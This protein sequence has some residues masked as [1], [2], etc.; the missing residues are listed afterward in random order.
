MRDVEL[1]DR[2]RAVTHTRTA[3]RRMR[4]FVRRDGRFA[5]LPSPGLAPNGECGGEHGRASDQ[6]RAARRRSATFHPAAFTPAAVL[7]AAAVP[8]VLVAHA[9][10]LPSVRRVRLPGSGPTTP[11]QPL[12]T[13]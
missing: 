13:A 3:T 7:V 10:P 6:E 8:P 1:D 2:Y 11:D 12:A 9:L 4:A 5:Y